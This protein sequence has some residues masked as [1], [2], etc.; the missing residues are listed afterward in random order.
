MA[1]LYEYRM[2]TDAKYLK[3]KYKR[4]SLQ[5]DTAQDNIILFKHFFNGDNID[6]N[7]N[8]IIG[9]ETVN[10]KKK[11]LAELFISENKDTEKELEETMRCIKNNLDHFSFQPIEYIWFK[12]VIA[13]VENI[14]VCIS[15]A[16][17]KTEHFG[18]PL[19][20]VNKQFET[21]TEYKRRDII[22]TNCKFLQPRSPIP[23]EQTQHRLIKQSLRLG[24]PISVIITNI[25]KSG[26]PF[27]NL[28]SLKPVFDKK[29]NHFYNIGIQTEITNEPTN[30][31][32]IQNV[33]D[34]MH[35]LSKIKINIVT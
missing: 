14:P 30:I 34:L 5:K 23:E 7:I 27:H 32:N 18:F 3:N 35:I 4:D 33:I 29:G 9:E 1:I 26:K 24:I 25:K 11:R 13:F 20:Y 8:E 22:G 31:I 16:C 6:K 19:I 10:E 15:I 12:N 28:I 21:V 17:S 2:E